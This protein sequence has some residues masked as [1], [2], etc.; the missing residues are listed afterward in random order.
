[1]GNSSG[2]SE[3]PEK[4]FNVRTG[5]YPTCEWDE[6]RVSKLILSKK[7]APFFPPGDTPDERSVECPICCYNYPSS[8]KTACCKKWICSEC[9]LQVRKPDPVRSKCPFCNYRKLEVEYRGAKTEREIEEEK[10]EEQSLAESQR[11]QLEEERQRDEQRRSSPEPERRPI[12][13]HDY[14]LTDHDVQSID[15]ASRSAASRSSSSLRRR[16]RELEAAAHGGQYVARFRDL[17]Q[18]YLDFVPSSIEVAN[19]SP[20]LQMTYEELMVNEAIRLSLAASA[21]SSTAPAASSENSATLPAAAAVPTGGLVAVPAPA[22]VEHEGTVILAES[23]AVASTTA[24]ASVHTGRSSRINSEQ[25]QSSRPV[26][27]HTAPVPIPQSR[28]TGASSSASSAASS[29]SSISANLD[30]EY[31]SDLLMIEKRTAREMNGLDMRQVVDAED[32][33]Y[34]VQLAIALSIS[35]LEEE[36]NQVGGPT[37]ASSVSIPASASASSALSATPS[38]TASVA[39]GFAAESAAGAPTTVSEDGASP[40]LTVSPVA[41][42]SESAQSMPLMADVQDPENS[43][44]VRSVEYSHEREAMQALDSAPSSADQTAFMESRQNGDFSRVS[45]ELTASRVSAA[46]FADLFPEQ[47]VELQHVDIPSARRRMES[48]D[49]LPLASDQHPPLTSGCVSD[50]HPSSMSA[51]THDTPPFLDGDGP[52]SGSSG[53]RSDASPSPSTEANLDIISSL[54]LDG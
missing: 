35:M 28:G 48:P 52:L 33:E 31:A 25:S 13:L 36:A 8:N 40:S 46:P 11:R 54:A 1:M 47:A 51:C 53:P 7:L 34:L 3:G 16:E 29:L 21:S 44:Q 12:N 18:E 27:A 9:Y 37:S 20:D 10:R 42:S 4:R 41:S 50:A 23:T 15:R 14:G 30:V 43:D 19:W 45:E 49:I 24:D 26:S 39:S 2:K 5:I 38:A 32:E 22:V 17:P 6:K